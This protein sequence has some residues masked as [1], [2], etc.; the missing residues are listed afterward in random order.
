MIYTL[1]RHHTLNTLK[2]GIA[3]AKLDT[4]QD[5]RRAWLF[6]EGGIEVEVEAPAM[7]NEDIPSSNY[8]MMTM[9]SYS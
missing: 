8:P 3:N 6:F 7:H 1:S 2:K 5:D 4:K 9:T